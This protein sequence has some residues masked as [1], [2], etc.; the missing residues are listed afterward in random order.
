M[1]ETTSLDRQ[2]ADMLW[3]VATALRAGYPIRQVFGQLSSEAPEPTASACARLAADLS[4]GLAL[5]Q[6]ITNWQQTSP[7]AY[8]PYVAAV[9][10]QYQQTGGNLPDLLAPV[11]EQLL[12]IAGTDPAFY[13]AMRGLAQ[14]V[15]ATL[16]PRVEES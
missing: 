2:L 13:P 8:L 14:S 6:A 11:G 3:M 9:V 12:E 15:G 10:R 1:I 4:S 7:S 16:P 5:D